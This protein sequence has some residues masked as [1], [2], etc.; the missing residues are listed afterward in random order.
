MSTAVDMNSKLVGKLDPMDKFLKK[1]C[2]VTKSALRREDQSF[3]PLIVDVNYT[4]VMPTRGTV[5][6]STNCTETNNNMVWF[7]PSI[8]N[9]NND[10]NKMLKVVMVSVIIRG[11]IVTNLI[12]YPT[13]IIGLRQRSF[14]KKYFDMFDWLEYSQTTNRMYCTALDVG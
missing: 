13:I 9:L 12:H 10:A 14:S 2:V 4:N 3:E 5:E 8:R 7:D 6:A 11:R 1:K